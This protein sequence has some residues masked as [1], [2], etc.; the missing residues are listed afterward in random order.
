MTLTQQLK[1]K[2]EKLKSEGHSVHAITISGVKYYYRSINRKEYKDL[3]TSLLKMTESL[4]GNKPDAEIPLIVKDSGEEDLVRLGL[5][6]PQL[7]DNTPAGVVT[8][9]ADRV[10]EASGFGVESE[11]EVL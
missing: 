9:L 5:I 8:S 7:S 6:E 3:Q 11:P 4:K 10:M 1:D 2:I